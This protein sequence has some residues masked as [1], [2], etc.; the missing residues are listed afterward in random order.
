MQMFA[1]KLSGA[2]ELRHADYAL[3]LRNSEDSAYS[4][5]ADVLDALTDEGGKILAIMDGFDRP[6]ANGQLTRNLWDQLRELGDKPSLTFITASRRTQREL[7]WNPDH[8]TSPFWNSF[9]GSPV[10]ISCFDEADLTAVLACL[11][12][13]KLTEGAKGELWK[14]SN[15]F[16]IMVLEVLNA[17]TELGKTGEINAELLRNACEVAFPGLCD[18][19][20]LLWMECSPSCQDLLLHVAEKGTLARKGS[21]NLD[22]QTLIER[23]FLQRVGDDLQRPKPI[24]RKVSG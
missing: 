18:K 24:P 1:R 4:D 23:G 17:L 3:H 8:E 21:S 6:M 11:P 15:G 2:C 9:E 19:I 7:I 5:I 22:E 14:V 20:H 10:R 13:S 16:P 12:N